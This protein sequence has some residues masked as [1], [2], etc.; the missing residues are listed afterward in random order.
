[1]QNIKKKD[2][3]FKL[4]LK[5]SEKNEIDGITAQEIAEKA[6]ISR[7]NASRY[8][9]QLVKENKIIKNS[10][11]PVIYK[12]KRK[13]STDPINTKIKSLEDVIGAQESLKIPVQQ[14]KAAI[15]YPPKGLHTL[16]LGE[17][18]VGKS[19]FAKLMY[20]FSISEEVLEADAPFIQFNC[21]DYADNPQL[22][23][24]QLFGVKKGAYTGADKDKV[25]LLKKADGGIIFL[26]EV[27]R[28]PPQ[29]QEMLFT[30]IDNGFFKPLGETSQKIKADL[31]IIAATTEA[32]GSY[33]LQTFQRRIPMVIELPNLEARTLNERYKL[34]EEFIKN[35][36]Q[37]VT[38][39]IYIYKNA[40]KSFLLYDC[41]N[42]IGQL[43]SDIQL[44]CAKAFLNYK[45]REDSKC[46]I[47][48]IGQE[49]LPY[50]VK[51]GIMNLPE[52]REKINDL[53]ADKGNLISFSS[54]Q[55][56][57][58]ETVDKEEIPDSDKDYYF[59]DNIEEKINS[60]EK[61]GMNRD[62]ISEILNIDIEKHFQKYIGNISKNFKK[63]KINKIVGE[64]IVN[65]VDRIFTL[66]R[67]RLNR[68][69][70]EKIYYGLALHLKR[71]IARIK[72]GEKIY[73]PKLNE[74]RINYS[75]EF[76]TA[77]EIASLIDQE[78]SV[79]TPLDEIGYLTMF[80]TERPYNF[81][82]EEEV[83]KVGIIVVMHGSSTASS[84][85]E[86]ANN[87]IGENHA[88]AIDMPLEMNPQEAYKKTKNKAQKIANGSGIILM[89]DMG[90]LNS[91][92]E[93][94]NN[95]TGINAKTITM[96]STPQV[97]E[98]CR[99]A[100]LGES[101]EDIINS[102]QKIGAESYQQEFEVS[103]EE[104]LES[105]DRSDK[106]FALVTACFTGDG[107]AVQ[108][109]E[110]LEKEIESSLDI[111]VINLNLLDQEEFET[112][113]ERLKESF[114][115][116]SIITTINK[117][118]DNIPSFSASDIIIDDGIDKI[119]NIIEK[120]EMYHK[121][122]VSIDKHLK[123]LDSFVIVED[124]RDLIKETK[125]NFNKT[126]DS[127][128]EIGILMHM[129]YMVDN[130]LTGGRTVKFDNLAEYKQANKEKFKEIKNIIKKLE[131]KY[132]IKITEDEYA[133]ILEMFKNN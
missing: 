119:K 99:K 79:E 102:V 117:K 128:V 47:L 61:S 101:I 32:P 40:L 34:I 65:I 115:I 52:N 125:N 38:K 51:K 129:V 17:T 22:L 112:N 41:P 13:I 53:I 11:R 43:K 98:A 49:E 10:G 81:H 68:D 118:I 87:L 80:L 77:M 69:Y 114:K 110:I 88:V 67:S 4:F 75:K 48:K 74:I 14:A 5:L 35:E 71:S 18:G 63:S 16:I 122:K 131:R 133:Y 107:A 28:L 121:I 60:L 126:L 64:D 96:S 109:K 76:I 100:V 58:L 7:S 83:K 73:H 1:M 91:F 113:I 15:L 94:I 85:A 123:N 111:K 6:D 70:D 20:N 105:E 93:M 46:D 21:A 27:H 30:F 24:G 23:M 42:N 82:G 108:I 97:L 50:H 66:A 127:G 31:K 89:V 56:G 26:D 116:I 84:I 25:G 3:I 19:M 92:A 44:A 36:V 90:S 62:E 95:E 120:E 8:L 45:A 104:E 55:S 72:G 2:K 78:F 29:G 54:N 37:R 57:D 9:N 12:K 39:D 106:N 124:I 132:K 103:S 86:V 130:L 33:L 59:Y